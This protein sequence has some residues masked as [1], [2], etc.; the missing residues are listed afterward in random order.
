MRS[1]SLFATLSFVLLSVAGSVS[2]AQL[3]PVAAVPRASNNPTTITSDTMDADL[4]KRQAIFRGNVVVKDDAYR[5]KAR[6]LVVRFGAGGGGLENLVATGDVL[7]EQADKSATAQK[8]T[9]VV[10][11]AKIV[12]EGS[13]KV[14]EKSGSTLQGSTIIFYRNTNKVQVDGKTSLVI[15]NPGAVGQFSPR[16]SA[17]PST[18]SAP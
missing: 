4:A 12:L 2:L 13:P 8:A 15:D 7:I 6:E 16:P 5:I 17:P 1:F 14:T 11:D 3:Q 18:P 10:A 9:Y